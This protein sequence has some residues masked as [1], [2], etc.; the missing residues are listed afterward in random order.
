M[1]KIPENLEENCFFSIIVVKIQH[2]IAIFF[3]VFLYFDENI[4]IYQIK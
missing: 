3:K 1:L 2:Y 4:V